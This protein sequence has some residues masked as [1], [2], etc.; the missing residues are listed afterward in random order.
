MALYHRERT[1]IGQCVDTALYESAFS[2]MENF[3]PAYEKLGEVP[4][5]TGSRL[6]GHVPNNLFPT[7]DGSHIHIAAGNDSTFRRLAETMGQEDLATDPRFATGDRRTENH[8]E[9]DALV[10]AWTTKHTLRDL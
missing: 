2:L 9:L 5:R 7:G 6:P 1:G 10:A 4:T 3:V 8:A